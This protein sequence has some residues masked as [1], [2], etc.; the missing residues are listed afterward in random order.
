MIRASWVSASAGSLAVL[1]YKYQ[2]IQRIRLILNTRAKRGIAVFASAVLAVTIAFG[3]YTLKK[4]SANGKLFIWEVTLGKIAEKPLFGHGVGRFAAEYNNWQAGYFQEHPGQAEGIRGWVAGNTRY[5]FNEFLEIASET[6]TVGLA[7]FLVLI[8]IS[9]YWAN[10]EKGSRNNRF[11]SPFILSFLI[12]MC[13]SFPLYNL[14]FTILFFIGLALISAY[15]HVPCIFMTNHVLLRYIFPVTMSIGC[16]WLLFISA[17]TYN[18]YRI[19]NKAN[20]LFK[21]SDYE[22]Q[23]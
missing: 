2:Y 6:G 19:W 17:T 4:D 16:L 22:K 1:I 11:I 10:K 3:L 5:C 18:T 7:L 20:L 12:L 9:V 8:G 21:I 23:I 14:S 15:I 13:V